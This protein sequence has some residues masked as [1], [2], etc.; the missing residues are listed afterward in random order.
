MALESGRYCIVPRGS[1]V[2]AHI[3]PRS[4]SMTRS[5]ETIRRS[6]RSR[7]R[8]ADRNDSFRFKTARRTTPKYRWEKQEL[9]HNNPKHT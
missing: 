4:Y 9:E 7:H 5:Q 3:S 8:K 1:R 2:P 6:S